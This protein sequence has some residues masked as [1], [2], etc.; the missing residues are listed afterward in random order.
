M[1]RGAE[2]GVIVLQEECTE[3]MQAANGWK[4]VQGLGN[5]FGN[6]RING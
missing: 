6:G 4:V 3:G 1:E 2:D 5:G